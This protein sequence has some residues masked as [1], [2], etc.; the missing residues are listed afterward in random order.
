MKPRMPSVTA[1]ATPL[2]ELRG[3]QTRKRSQEAVEHLQKAARHEMV[4]EMFD[5]LDDRHSAFLER[6]DAKRDRAAAEPLLERV[7]ETGRLLEAAGEAAI[8][9]KGPQGMTLHPNICV[10][11]EHPNSIAVEASQRRQELALSAEALEPALTRCGD[12]RRGIQFARADAVPPTLG[13]A[14]PRHEAFR[15]I[16]V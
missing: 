9:D 15:T 14:R 1:E 7:G 4:G 5:R 6:H 2:K 8:L 12:G 11:L 10:A 3:G 16:D 13:A